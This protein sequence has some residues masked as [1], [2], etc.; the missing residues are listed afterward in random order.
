LTARRES[1]RLTSVLS[2]HG[3][4]SELD[5]RQAEQLVYTASE[6]IPDLE[7]AFNRKKIS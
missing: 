2:N 5:V 7:H 1:L 4:T 3:N 6:E